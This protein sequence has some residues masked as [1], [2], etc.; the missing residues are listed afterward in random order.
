MIYEP[1]KGTTVRFKFKHA[2]PAVVKKL[3][4]RH[5][6]FA[7]NVL[8]LSDHRWPTIL[9]AIA[10]KSISLQVQWFHEPDP[11]ES[12]WF[13]I[14]T[15]VEFVPAKRPPKHA[16]LGYIHRDL[17]TV[18]S[19]R[20]VTVV[21][22]A[23]LKGLSFLPLDEPSPSS[24]E[25]WHEIF[26]TTP[27][28]RGIDHP[29][30]DR[31]RFDRGVLKEVTLR[32]F[33]TVRHGEHRFEIAM[34]RPGVQYAD[35]VFAALL[36]HSCTRDTQFFAGDSTFGACFATEYAPAVDFAYTGW[37]QYKSDVTDSPP[38]H[39]NLCC[40]RR[41]R[42]V[43]LAAKLL[44]PRDFV[45]IKLISADAAQGT[46]WDRE[47]S[48]PLPPPAY[49]PAEAAAERTRRLAAHAA[50]PA[51]VARRAPKTTESM[52]D[53][54]QSSAKQHEW[55]PVQATSLFKKV[56]KNKLHSLLPA[57]WLALLPHVPAKIADQSDGSPVPSCEIATP[58]WNTTT[59][60]ENSRSAAS[61][62]ST[63]DLILAE[64]VVGDW[65]SVRLTNDKPP[66]DAKVTHWD[67]E[68]LTAVQTWPTV[69]AFAHV[70]MLSAEHAAK[71]RT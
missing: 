45:A 6:Q 33:A 20:W 19:A 22:A 70:L 71:R 28:G 48:T 1:P 17:R 18:A 66:R 67:H 51:G 47:L 44:K 55:K 65:F 52:I 50:W 62:P 69:I 25:Q 12:E 38:R 56:A 7:G 23:K 68:T 26:A 60:D 58:A 54:L 9:E 24:V 13:G 61:R 8:K 16:S 32:D 31:K 49:T 30:L 41:A 36:Q 34:I 64:S 43:L 59:A 5:E 57:N 29:L 40:S 14:Y 27:L 39:R 11:P 3:K 63:R 2:D 15:P 21:N 4:L 42:E 10:K 37:T 46:V 53:L 35:K